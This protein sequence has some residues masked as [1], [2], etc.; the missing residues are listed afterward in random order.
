MAEPATLKVAERVWLRS[1][2]IGRGEPAGTLGV[3]E[4][5]ELGVQPEQASPVT[6]IE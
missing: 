2:K 3:G 5:R 6:E 1:S 4:R